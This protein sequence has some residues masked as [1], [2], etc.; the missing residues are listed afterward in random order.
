MLDPGFGGI[1]IGEAGPDV[2]GIGDSVR[3]GGLGN[4]GGIDLGIFFNCLHG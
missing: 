2:E 1:G 3:R 4:F